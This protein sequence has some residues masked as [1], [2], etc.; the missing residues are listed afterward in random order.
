MGIDQRNRVFHGALRNHRLA[1]QG[2]PLWN[3]EALTTASNWAP[4]ATAARAGPACQASSQISSRS[5]CRPARRHSFAHR[6]QSSAVRRT[7]QNWAAAA[8]IARNLLT[9]A[10]HAGSVEQFLTLL[11]ALRVT[12]DQS[13]PRPLGTGLLQLLQGRI[14]GFQKCRT[15]IQVLSR[16]ATQ[17]KLGREQQ[18]G[19]VGISFSSS[20]DDFL[21]IAREVSHNKIALGTANG[22]HES[23]LGG[24]ATSPS[25]NQGMAEN[26]IIT[27]VL[28]SV[29]QLDAQT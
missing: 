15:Q 16:V 11:I 3:G 25:D 13:Q 12:D 14:A 29:Q 4:A 19:T 8:E 24:E 1:L 9:I 2:L 6:P 26:K 27:R 7:R 10:Q 28:A 17:G 20:G 18:A 23:K 21:D 5:G 22:R